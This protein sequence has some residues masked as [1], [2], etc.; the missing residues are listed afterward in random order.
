[1]VS[2]LVPNERMTWT[3]GFAPMLE[4][5]RT[6]ALTTCGDGSTRFAMQERFSGL[7]LPF[8]RRSFPDFGLVFERY[9][10]D[11]KH[12]AERATR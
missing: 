12:E 10:S 11:L 6:F 8:I 5:V 7:L 2:D 1:V 4:G 9:A 3:G